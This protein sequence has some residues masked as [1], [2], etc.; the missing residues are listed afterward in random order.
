VTFQVTF[1]AADP[2]RLAGFWAEALGYVVQPPPPGFETWPA[3][4]AAQGVPAQRWGAAAAIVDP[5][6]VQP[7]VFFQ[8]VPEGKTAKNRVHLD[9]GVGGG[10]GTP[11]DVQRERVRAE[12]E[13]LT[14]LG[15]TAIEE[16]EELGVVWHIMR[17]PEG[18]EFCV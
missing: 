5:Q 15:A 4:L 7:R 12:V 14:A 18:D 8:R 6:G 9:L 13:R 1:D 10:P 2:V 17:D 11:L 16:H 3:F